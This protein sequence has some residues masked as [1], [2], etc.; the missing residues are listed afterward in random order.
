MWTSLQQIWC[1]IDLD[2]SCAEVYSKIEMACSAV[3]APTARGRWGKSAHSA[4]LAPILHLTSAHPTSA[5]HIDHLKDFTWKAPAPLLHLQYTTQIDPKDFKWNKNSRAHPKGS[6]KILHSGSPPR[7]KK[8][9]EISVLDQKYLF[10]WQ[11]FSFVE[12]G[13]TPK[14]APL[15]ENHSAKKKH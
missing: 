12:L 6:C 7:Q 9:A 10:F 2:E 4:A 11:N 8:Q 14:G 5:A 3:L 1:K 15:R 13:G